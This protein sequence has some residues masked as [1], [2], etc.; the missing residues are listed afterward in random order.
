MPS[1]TDGSTAA[2][3]TTT[4][5]GTTSGTTTPPDTGNET[6]TDTGTTT[7]DSACGE[8]D[9]PAVMALWD[10][11]VNDGPP[12][13]TIS[14]PCTVTAS[15]VAGP[16]WTLGLDCTI[17]GQTAAVDLLITRAP[18]SGPTLAVGDMRVLE[19]RAEQIFWTN[20]WF[21][22]HPEGNPFLVA[23]AGIKADHVAPPGMTAKDF[24]GVAIAV[25]DGLCAPI[26]LG[27]CGPTIR[28]ALDM[29]WSAGN[30]LL[31]D[32]QSGGLVDLGGTVGVWVAKAT[33]PNDRAACDDIPPAWFEVVMAGSFGP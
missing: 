16:Q 28:L 6:S 2:V 24:F 31:F 30:K 26:D 5:P 4:D 21:S 14:A 22:I 15:D 32:G 33:R 23:L 17:D 11:H 1:T 10:I 7:G 13:G 9:A 3:T 19:Y 18:E 29:T 8:P 12:P 27:P 25:V 20:E